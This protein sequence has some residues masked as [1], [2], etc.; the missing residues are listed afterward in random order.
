MLIERKKR[1][2]QISLTPL[3]DVVFLLVVF[4]MLSTRFEMIE[5]MEIT[6]PSGASEAGAKPEEIWMMRV[7]KDG[8]VYSDD[9]D[10]SISELDREV[11]TRLAKQADLPVMVIAR[12]ATT[13]QQLVN[14]LDVLYVN[15]ASS[16]QMDYETDYDP[17]RASKAEMR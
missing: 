7:G 15:G 10:F 17:A 5:S 1:R 12:E 13:V 4:F 2:S 3:I 9:E 14:V 8:R 16:V 6:L 11:R